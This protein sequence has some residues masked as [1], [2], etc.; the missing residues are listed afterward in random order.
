VLVP[1]IAITAVVSTYKTKRFLMFFHDDHVQVGAAVAEAA[2]DSTMEDDL[3]MLQDKCR[4]YIRFS[5]SPEG[6]KT[7]IYRLRL[8]DS[9]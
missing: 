2:R 7:A 5:E 9:T 6:S 4:L 1:K 8:N 3:T